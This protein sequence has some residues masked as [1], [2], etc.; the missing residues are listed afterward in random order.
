MSNNKTNVQKLI[1]KYLR[2][3]NISPLEDLVTHVEHLI[4]EED[5]KVKPRYV[6]ART[7]KTLVAQDMVHLHKT[8]RSAYVQLTSEGRNKLRSL[9][10]SADDMIVPQS[11]DGKWRIVIL[12]IPESNKKVRDAL[13]YILKKA[14]FSLLKN[15]VWISPYPFEH[16]L[17]NMKKDLGLTDE[18]II[19]VTESIDI[20]PFE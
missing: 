14:H 13:R 7:I 3:R 16:F 19:I 1:L 2:T 17:A 9:L 4:E 5:R 18:M 6:I 20:N 12:D 8:E 10:L 15:S 11:W